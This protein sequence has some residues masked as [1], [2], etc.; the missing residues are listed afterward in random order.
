MDIW[1]G[2]WSLT[3]G[4]ACGI[5]GMLM[6]LA[7]VF[8][9]R[10]RGR[11]WLKCLSFRDLCSQVDVTTHSQWGDM[12]QCGGFW[13]TVEPCLCRDSYRAMGLMGWWWE[14]AML[15]N[16]HPFR[17]G[18]VREAYWE[19]LGPPHHLHSLCLAVVERLGGGRT[20]KRKGVSNTV[21]KLHPCHTFIIS[22]LST[23]A[24]DLRRNRT[25]SMHHQNAR[26]LVCSSQ[27]SYMCVNHVKR[28]ENNRRSWVSQVKG[29]TSGSQ[30]T[31]R[32]SQTQQYETD[33]NQLVKVTRGP[34]RRNASDIAVQMK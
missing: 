26:A 18:P 11:L 4:H 28:K 25:D 6:L 12:R 1:S 3:L 9:C 15:G 21:H 7:V 30:L 31:C 29:M 16:R 22:V 24:S 19:S 33:R 17:A 13:D 8:W 2:K 20:E 5:W 34:Q 10:C 14:T 23:W 27:V 32:A